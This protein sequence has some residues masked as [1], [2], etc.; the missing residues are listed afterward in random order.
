[1]SVPKSEAKSNN[2]GEAVLCEARQIREDMQ[3]LTEIDQR[4]EVIQK[5]NYE[6]VCYDCF[7]RD[8]IVLFGILCTWVS[9][10]QSKRDAFNI[11]SELRIGRKHSKE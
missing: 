5:I 7:C 10:F 6:Q 3:R 1:M 9:A 8:C 11:S 4:L 2:P